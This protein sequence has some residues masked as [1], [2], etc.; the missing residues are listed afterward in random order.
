MHPLG[1]SIWEDIWK[2]TVEKSRIN[3][4]NV[5]IHPLRQAIWGHIWKR[6]VEKSQTNATNVTMHPLMRAIWGDIW[7]GTCRK[8]K[9]TICQLEQILWGKNIENL[10]RVRFQINE[11]KELWWRWKVCIWAE[12]YLKYQ[13][14]AG[15]GVFNR[16]KRT[17]KQLKPFSPV[18]PLYLLD[19]VQ[20]VQIWTLCNLCISVFWVSALHNKCWVY[21]YFN[22][23][24]IAVS[25]G[26]CNLKIQIQPALVVQW[27]IHKLGTQIT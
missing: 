22:S 11:I 5:T 23:L 17:L 14:W 18:W 4:N 27:A 6:T 3:A 7:R 16:H 21:L 26:L 20:S 12:A 13:V 15:S 2:H 24:V 19:C 8:K 1:Q 10:E 25:F 9:I